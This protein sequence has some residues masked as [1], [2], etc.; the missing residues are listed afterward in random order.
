MKYA[1]TNKESGKIQI[2][3]IKNGNNISLV[4]QDDGS[5]LPSGFDRKKLESFGLSLIDM[6]VDQL[7]GSFEMENDNGT[8]CTIKFCI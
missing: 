7:E 2:F 8:K 1:F 5:G 4:V 3:I 6:L